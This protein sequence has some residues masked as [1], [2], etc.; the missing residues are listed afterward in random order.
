MDFTH[1]YLW[2][3]VFLPPVDKTE[4]MHASYLSKKE[5]MHLRKSSLEAP[6]PMLHIN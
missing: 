6:N 1:R 5:Y 4:Y 2:A 3:W